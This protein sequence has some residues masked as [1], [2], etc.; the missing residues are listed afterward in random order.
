MP[1]VTGAGVKGIATV[2][3]MVDCVGMLRAG[4]VVEKSGGCSDI[5][6]FGKSAAVKGVKRGGGGKGHYEVVYTDGTC[7]TAVPAR[8]LRGSGAGRR[9]QFLERS[10][11]SRRA[12]VA[13]IQNHERARQVRR[14]KERESTREEEEER[15]ERGEIERRLERE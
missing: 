5:T 14:A 13:L 1:G 8:C 12:A 7:A 4:S 6:S 10:S 11:L 15:D 2:K 9:R 3:G